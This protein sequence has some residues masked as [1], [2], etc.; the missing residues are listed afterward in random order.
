MTDHA[1]QPLALKLNQVSKRFGDKLAVD[2]L[3]LEVPRGCFFA[4][5]GHNGAGKT[6]SLRMVAGLSQPT[7]GDIEILGHS[8]TRDPMNAKR[9]LAFL[10]DE[11]MVYGKLR[12]MEYLSY[13]AGLWGIPAKAAQAK[14]EELL[15]WTELWDHRQELVEGFSRGMQQK[16]G[17]CGALIH[18]PEVLLLDEPLTGLDAMAAKQVK[19]MLAERVKAGGTVVL[20][21][22][23]LEVAERLAE[24]IAIVRGGR[25]VADGSLAQLRAQTGMPDATLESIFIHL[26]DHDL[27]AGTGAAA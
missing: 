5:L 11:A 12:P 13:V 4:F 22:H 8:I 7:E 20:T 19:D 25:L 16:L 18:D 23:I 9:K 14:A 2:R 27:T 15:N 24:R 10:P 6:T 1:S 26:A 3:S 17:L 21:T